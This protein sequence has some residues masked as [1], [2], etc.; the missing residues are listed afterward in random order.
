MTVA[1]VRRMVKARGWYATARFLGHR[2][3][4]S[5]GWFLFAVGD[6]LP[7]THKRT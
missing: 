1:D 4:G 6:M 3:I 7:H 2:N 5:P